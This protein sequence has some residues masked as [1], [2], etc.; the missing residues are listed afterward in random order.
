MNTNKTKNPP[1]L[2]PPSKL[3][4]NW[5]NFQF[6]TGRDC[7]N[8]SHPIYS[9]ITFKDHRTGLRNVTQRPTKRAR[10]GDELNKEDG[11]T[12]LIIIIVTLAGW[13]MGGG[14][15]NTSGVKKKKCS[16]SAPDVPCKQISAV[17][18]LEIYKC[19]GGMLQHQGVKD[20]SGS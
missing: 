17:N 16:M 6:N 20:S 2:A 13:W 10:N 18:V 7:N 3:T 14:N 19:K 12:I 9:L 11:E 4:S 15:W 8:R 1:S 5:G